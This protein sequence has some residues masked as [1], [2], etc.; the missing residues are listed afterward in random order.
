[1]GWLS[2]SS[3]L[4]YLV[5]AAL[6]I[7]GLKYLGSPRTAPRGNQLGAIG[8]LIAVVVTLL[9]MSGA[10]GGLIGLPLILIGLVVGGAIGAF[11]AKKVEMTG[12]PEMVGL[13]N[14][15][16]GGASALVALAEIVRAR[17]AFGAGRAE[18]LGPTVFVLAIG[19]SSLIG[20][21]TLTGSLV[22]VLK[23]N[24]TM[25]KNIFLPGQNLLKAVL[26]LACIACTVGLIYTPGNLLLI[27][28]LVLA[29]AM[30]GVLFVIP[31][32]GA[33][34]PVVV[35]FLNSLSGCA[36]SATGFVVGNNA[37][38]ISGA[39]V[40]AAGL[41]L[42]GIMC[43][44]MNRKFADV[45]FKAYGATGST[46]TGEKRTVQGYE[47]E[48]AALAFDGART[49][50]IVP[51]YGM[52]VSQA[53]HV[54]RELADELERRGSEVRFAIHPVA[55]RMPG[56]MNVLLAEANVPYEQ[57]FE[58]D[59]INSSFSECDVALVVG[60]ND[61]VNPAAHTDPDGPLGGMPV[62]DV[63][64]ART[65]MIVKRSLS[66]GYA[67]VD[68]D[69]FYRPSTMMLF[70]DGKKKLTDL[71]GAVKEL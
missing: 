60:A 19:A 22:A 37:L 29:A 70:G 44:A 45:V 33:D 48:E 12:M 5:A 18:G 64:K 49:V 21:V 66:P 55:G 1:M 23:L 61:T 47:A 46:D 13:F 31:I 9:R 68:N 51:G 20:W 35:S 41:I 59:D 28:A 30:L 58:L 67:G 2:Y 8:M 50:I 17:D 53:Q 38:I 16:G 71:L 25:R 3:D 10:E 54:V 39:L 26:L 6:F 40:G 34:M 24:G 14:G 32:G 15:F 62:L 69:L 27:T 4:G 63:E 52:A 65:V 43:K 42:T 57:L 7:V 56:H 36:A 11:M